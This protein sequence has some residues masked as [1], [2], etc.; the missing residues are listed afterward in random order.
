MGGELSLQATGHGTRGHASS[1]YL[2]LQLPVVTCSLLPAPSGYLWLPVAPSGYLWL[3]TPSGYLLL[4]L[5]YLQVLCHQQAQGLVVAVLLCACRCV[6][7]YVSMFTHVRNDGCVYTSVCVHARDLAHTYTQACGCICRYFDGV[8]TGTSW[9]VVLM[10][11]FEV[12]GRCELTR[13]RTALL[14]CSARSVMQV[15]GCYCLACVEPS[16]A[17]KLK[18]G[19]QIKSTPRFSKVPPGGDEEIHAQWVQFSCNAHQHCIT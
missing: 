15:R 3:P 2:L 4:Q 7:T 6:R 8:R 12:W 18:A 11:G 19:T 10:Q 1:G 14:C 16:S 13:Q 5:L 17:R 9:E